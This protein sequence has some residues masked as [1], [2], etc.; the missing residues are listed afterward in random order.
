MSNVVAFPISYNS[1]MR[2]RMLN[3]DMF[4]NLINLDD[5]DLIKVMVDLSPEEREIWISL[6]QLRLDRMCKKIEEIKLDMESLERVFRVND[7]L[8]R[9]SNIGDCKHG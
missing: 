1:P 6:V 3:E 5:N 9:L 7:E 4:T 2:M 8:C